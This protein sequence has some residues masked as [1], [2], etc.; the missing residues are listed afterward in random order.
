MFNYS[1]LVKT[2]TFYIEF[3]NKN[4]TE[5]LLVND[6]EDLIRYWYRSWFDK[7]TSPIIYWINL[8]AINTNDVVEIQVNLSDC[9]STH[10][11]TKDFITATESINGDNRRSLHRILSTGVNN[12]KTKLYK[13]N[14]DFVIT[15]TYSSKVNKIIDI[16]NP[17][18]VKDFSVKQLSSN[19][20]NYSEL[21]ELV[22]NLIEQE[23]SKLNQLSS[24]LDTSTK[25]VLMR[26]HLDKL[27][28]LGKILELATELDK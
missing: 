8:G 7:F 6:I 9:K 22:N 20:I 15:N 18:L 1:E 28:V 19:L 12:A 23:D 24:E 14:C 26:Q 4:S 3:L 5:D 10:Y 2:G 13:V 17:Y 11:V 21:I 16:P 27:E 25:Y